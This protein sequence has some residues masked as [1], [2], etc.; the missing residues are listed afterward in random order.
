VTAL[1]LNAAAAVDRSDT[2]GSLDPANR[3]RCGH[4]GAPVLPV[5]P[6]SHRSEQRGKGDQE[7]NSGFRQT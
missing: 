7:G 3:G 1:T 4:S 6:L 5:Y 2:I